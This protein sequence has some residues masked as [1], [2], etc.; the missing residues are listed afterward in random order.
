MRTAIIGAGAMG[1]LF[2]ALLSETGN[3]IWLVD[4]WAEHVEVIKRQGL[5]V[6]GR[7][8]PRR[9]R[10]N[11][12]TQPNEVGDVDLA[13]VFVKS[14]HTG[15]AAKTA[16]EL[17]LPDG[18]ALTL[19]N[20]LGNAEILAQHLGPHRVMAGTT[21]HGATLVGPG[22]I[23]HAGSG[24]TRIGPW[25]EVP[26]V[27][28][29]RLRDLFTSSGIETELVEDIREAIWEKLLV[30]VGINA[31]TALTGITNGQ[32][33]EME[34]TRQLV[35][36]AVSEAQAVARAKGIKVRE[37][38]VQHVFEVAEATA[39]NRSSMG[40]DVDRGR[41]TE[42]EAINGA[43]WREAMRHSI[44]APVNFTLTALVRTLEAHRT[45]AA[46]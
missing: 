44:D 34:I 20:G 16:K 14:M 24:P 7:G 29:R 32:L 26:G 43:V 30:N 22:H 1:S 41:P 12:T 37:D 25:G 33:L 36:K 11:A 15:D 31:V 35:A 27:R 6:E 10:L 3:P 19:Q 40:Q 5:L 45:S 18:I 4:L 8:Q 46:K 21:S 23:R 38:A 13:I 9:I 28:A 39:Q 17:L 2:G 42:I